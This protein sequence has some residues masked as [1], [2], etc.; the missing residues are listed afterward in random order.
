MPVVR[1]GSLNDLIVRAPG[2][3]FC[4]VVFAHFRISESLIGRPCPPFDR[5]LRVLVMFILVDY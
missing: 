1:D 5:A 2:L 3:P 4:T